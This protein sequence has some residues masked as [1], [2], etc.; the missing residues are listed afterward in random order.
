MTMRFGSVSVALWL[1]G[2]FTGVVGGPPAT[3]D[4]KEALQA[5]SSRVVIYGIPKSWY[6]RSAPTA[7]TFDAFLAENGASVEIRVAQPKAIHDLLSSLKFRAS[8]DPDVY[9]VRL[10]IDLLDGDRKVLSL[11][12]NPQG[13][14]K[15][16]GQALAAG[17]RDWPTRLF[18]L[19]RDSVI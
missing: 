18:R 19:I 7:A 3:L 8:S 11:Y 17:E 14:V 1:L 15:Y 16:E 12:V 5:R 9:N 2:F 6:F 10:R 4:L 13:D